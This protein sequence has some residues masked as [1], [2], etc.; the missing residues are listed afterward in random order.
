MA[1]EPLLPAALDPVIAPLGEHQV[2][3]GVLSVRPAPV[4]GE[5]IGQP[6][7][8]AHPFGE[9][10]CKLP[11]LGLAELLGKRELDLAVQRPLA[12]SCSSAASQYAPGSSSA[13]SGMFPCSLCSSSSRSCS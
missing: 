4:D 10:A 11:P 5:R 7:P 1:L 8:G 6:L 9:L 12:R 3:V 13:H 2:R